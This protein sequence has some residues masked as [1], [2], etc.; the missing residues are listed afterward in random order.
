[1]LTEAVVRTVS[2]I[3]IPAD[4]V[5][6]VAH[7][8]SLRRIAGIDRAIDTLT[9]SELRSLV[10]ARIPTFS[11]TLD[12]VAGRAALDVEVKAAGLERQIADLL[13]AYPHRNWVVSSFDWSVLLALQPRL[14]GADL[15]PLADRVTPALLST[16]ERLRSTAVAL[17]H[18]AVTEGSIRELA[19]A[20]LQVTAWTGNDEAEAI[21]LRD[22]GVAA[23]CS[24]DPER[25]MSAL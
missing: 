4:G 18:G 24:D 6:V 13:L 17:W 14:P 7:D 11:E 8:R 2:P 1:M 9:L 21:R 10:G 12:L 23:L 22:L 5:L 19:E 16:A 20:G 25:M 3:A 15:W